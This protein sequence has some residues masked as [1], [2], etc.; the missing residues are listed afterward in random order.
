M[1]HSIYYSVLQ[2]LQIISFLIIYKENLKQKQF[3]FQSH[4]KRKRE[5]KTKALSFG[6][7]SPP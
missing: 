6:L 3:T 7:I 2:L 5:I 1:K 4:T